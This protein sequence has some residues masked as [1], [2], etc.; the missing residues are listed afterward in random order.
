LSNP[1]PSEAATTGWQ[2][3]WLAEAAEDADGWR[4]W[5]LREDGRFNGVIGPMRAR[6]EGS[7]VRVRI[8]P[9]LAQANLADHIHGGATLTLI[10]NALFIGA[11]LLGPLANDRAVTADL[12]THFVGAGRI[13]V[14]LDAVVE[15][16]RATGRTVFLRGVVEQGEET[17]ADFT[18][19]MRKVRP[20]NSSAT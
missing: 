1:S 3:G 2:P 11:R 8:E 13:G 7:V 16:T 17:I 20:P 12:T 5:T 19:S 6:V 14:P 10:D 18:G 4:E 15:V 9:T